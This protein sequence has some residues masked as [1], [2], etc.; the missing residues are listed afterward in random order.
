ML[1]AM[2]DEWMMCR[3]VYVVLCCNF[4]KL[5][6]FATSVKA[7]HRIQDCMT[8]QWGTENMSSVLVLLNGQNK[9]FSTIVALSKGAV[10]RDFRPSVFFY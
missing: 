5:I 8:L 9:I 4:S 1:K 10:A 3:I 6:I 7:H 2:T